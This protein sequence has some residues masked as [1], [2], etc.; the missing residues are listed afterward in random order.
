MLQTIGIAARPSCPPLATVG[1]LPILTVVLEA[2]V[3]DGSWPADAVG[4]DL[5]MLWLAIESRD[6]ASGASVAVTEAMVV[7][8]TCVEVTTELSITASRV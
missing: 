6:E 8:V 1:P 7:V 5:T 3:V 4:V 2:V